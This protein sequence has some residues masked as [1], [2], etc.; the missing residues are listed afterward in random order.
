MSNG[1][2]R[3]ASFGVRAGG[4]FAK[5]AVSKTLYL[6]VVA[7]I[8]CSI[9]ALTI[10]LIALDVW[11][12]NNGDF[13]EHEQENNSIVHNGITYLPKEN[14]ETFLVLGLDTIAGAT[15]DSYNNNQRAD[16]LMLLV[17]DNN[18]KQCTALQINRDTVTNVNILGLAGDKVGSA[19]MQIALSH[20]Y[21]HGGD[22]SCRNAANAVSALLNDV[23]IDHYISVTME[24]VPTLNDLVGGVEVTLLEDFTHFD[25]TMVKGETMTLRGEQALQYVQLRKG[26]ED[27][28]NSTR[29]ERQQQYVNALYDKFQSCMSNDGGFAAEALAEVSDQIVSDRSI[30]QLEALAEKFNEYTF[31]GIRELSG[32]SKVVEDLME[33]YPSSASIQQTVIDLFYKPED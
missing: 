29:M 19:P 17:F 28:T 13:P 3:G 6:K 30:T 31:L 16:F 22:I 33:F 5:K 10:G 12:R 9:S 8:I 26:L 15:T 14:I 24:A 21:G 1:F 2:K 11:E 20:T 32:T 7:I 23:K 18:T 25:P 4:H 27:Q